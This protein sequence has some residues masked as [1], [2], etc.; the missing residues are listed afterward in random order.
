[1]DLVA[2]GKMKS[3]QGDRPHAVKVFAEVPGGIVDF[4]VPEPPQGDFQPP[5]LQ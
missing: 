1:M 2:D 3:V 4:P 5:A